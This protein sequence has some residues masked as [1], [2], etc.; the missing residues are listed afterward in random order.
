MDYVGNAGDVNINPNCKMEVRKLLLILYL[1]CTLNISGQSVP[2]IQGF[3]LSD[4][5]TVTG[6][7]RLSQ[8]FTNSIDC[9][10]DPTYKG[11]KDRLSNFRNYGYRTTIT[12]DYDTDYAGSVSPSTDTD[13]CGNALFYLY[14]TFSSPPDYGN[15]SVSVDVYDGATLQ[16]TDV[17]TWSSTNTTWAVVNTTASSQTIDPTWTVT[18]RI[19]TTACTRPT[20]LTECAMWTEMQSGLNVSCVNV[21]TARALSPVSGYA[22]EGLLTEGSDIYF[23][24]YS[25][26]CTKI[27]DGCYV[28]Q[29]GF[30]TKYAV[31][32][33]AGKLYYV[34]C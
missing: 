23:N 21:C 6:G 1:G 17:L 3:A 10:F 12:S 26:N 24:P 28:L 16:F 33:I 27:P 7:T 25:T 14:H 2:N 34:S 20:G 30:G 9:L 19:K 32:V 4:V 29:V 5:L 11:S 13:F 15:M 22:A 31:Q 18:Y 8:A